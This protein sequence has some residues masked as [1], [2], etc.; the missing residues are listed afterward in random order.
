MWAFRRRVLTALRMCNGRIQFDHVISESFTKTKPLI[1]CA[2]IQYV[3]FDGSPRWGQSAK[4]SVRY[5]Q[6]HR[7]HRKRV[8]ETTIL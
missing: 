5:H 4:T 8:L 6:S 2:R 1:I 7:P 3:A